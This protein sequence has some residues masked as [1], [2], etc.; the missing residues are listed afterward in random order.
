M[1]KF[2]KMRFLDVLLMVMLALKWSEYISLYS[3]SYLY[4]NGAEASSLAGIT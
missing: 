4:K 3:Y 2:N 1:L